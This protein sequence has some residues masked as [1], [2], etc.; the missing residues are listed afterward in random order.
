[1]KVERLIIG[2]RNKGKLSEWTNFLQDAMEVVPISDFSNVRDPQESGKTFEENARLKASGYAKQL[3]EYVFSEDGGFEVDYLGGAPGV[4]SRRILAGDQDATDEE[5]I[6]FIIKKLEGVPKEKR[7][8][9][10]RLVAAVSDPEGNIIWEERAYLEGLIPENPS[11][12]LSPGYPFRS[13]LFVPEAGKLYSEFTGE[14]HEK[15]NHKK[16]IAE[17]LKTFLLESK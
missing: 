14:D 11:S 10:L 17:K 7:T 6:D 12:E 13:V 5:I 2:T 15:F 9:R 8:A 1:M 16:V 4:K 3:G